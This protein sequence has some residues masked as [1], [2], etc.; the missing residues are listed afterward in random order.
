MGKIKGGGKKEVMNIK[1]EVPT[2]GG[3]CRKEDIYL[4]G[5]IYSQSNIYAIA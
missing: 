1:K 2:S 3:L 4:K 5:G